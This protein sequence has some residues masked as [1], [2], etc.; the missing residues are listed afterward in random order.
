MTWLRDYTGI[1]L[2]GGEPTLHPELH[3][4]CAYAKSTGLHV[5]MI[6]N[7]SRGSDL[8]FMR[9]LAQCGLQLLHV[10]IYSSRP[11][12][13]AILRGVPGTL[14]TAEAA[15]DAAHAVGIATN[16]N[17]VINKLNRDDWTRRQWIYIDV[18]PTCVTTSGTI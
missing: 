18:T 10:S 3:R 5:R 13:E 9:E 8:P 16:I 1:I 4:I 17:C 12:V 7:G 2:T 15:L 11:N 6:T 14:E